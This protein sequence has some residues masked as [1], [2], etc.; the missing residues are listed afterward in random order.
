VERYVDRKL[1]KAEDILKKKEHTA[2]RWYHS[3]INGEEPY[4]LKEIHIFLVAFAAG[5]AIGIVSGR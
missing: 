2:R 3:F 4:Q 1:D 5:V